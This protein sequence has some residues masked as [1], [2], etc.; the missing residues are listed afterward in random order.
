MCLPG[1]SDSKESVCNSG[2][3]GLIPGLG[4][5]PEEQN[6]YAL[7]YSCLEF[8]LFGGLPRWKVKVLVAQS[9]QTLSDPMDRSPPG[10][11]ICGVLLAGILGWVAI[12]RASSD[13]PARQCRRHS[14][15][16]SDPWVRKIPCRRALPLALA[17]LPGEP[18]GQTRMVD[19]SHR[20]TTEAT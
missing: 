2:D 17:F 13:R 10:S 18:H 1:G 11:P 9:C 8:Y 12:P 14:R 20:V 6:G 19:D 5:S 15:H 4:R 7:Q 3:Q 16:R